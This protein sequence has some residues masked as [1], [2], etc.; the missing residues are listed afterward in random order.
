MRITMLSRITRA[1][2]GLL[3][4]YAAACAPAPGTQSLTPTERAAARPAV[5][6]ASASPVTTDSATTVWQLSPFALLQRGN[7]DGVLTV[8]EVRTHGSLGLGAAD[9][10]NGEVAVVDGRFYQFLEGGRAVTPPE[11]MRMPFAAV[12]GRIGE[13]PV[14]LRPGLQ[15]GSTFQAAVD[16]MLPTTDAFYAL[17]L[18]GTWD[19][20]VARTYRRQSKPYPPLD[21]VAADTFTVRGVQGTMVGFRQPPYAASLS[22]P[23]YHLHFI[24]ASGTRGGHVL[25]F[26]TRDVRLQVSVRPDFTLRMPPAAGSPHAAVGGDNRIRAVPALAARGEHRP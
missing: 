26:T 3:V 18:E 14:P 24:D 16:A 19:V 2:G 11:S 22:V 25:G 13:P 1:A 21:S 12:T 5:S 7:Y 23:N 10:L 8:A 17:R 6:G 9:Q 20:V 15:Y 4:A